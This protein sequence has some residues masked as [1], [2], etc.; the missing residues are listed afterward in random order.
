MANISEMIANARSIKGEAS[1]AKSYLMRYDVPKSI[2]LMI[3]ALHAKAEMPIVSAD[4]IDIEL[5]VR[6]YCCE[7]DKNQYVREVLTNVAF[8]KPQFLN[9]SPEKEREVI[10]RLV[11]MREKMAEIEMGEQAV[12]QKE[13]MEK[14]EALINQGEELV[15]SGQLPKGRVALKRAAE[16]FGREPGVLAR[17]GKILLDA[18]E[19]KEA[20]EM[21][22]QAMD[23]HPKDPDG[24]A[25][26]VEACLAVE[27]LPGAEDAYL[28]AIKQFGE[29]PQTC[30]NLAK[31]YLR[32]RNRDK[33]EECAR[34]AY[35]LDNTLA[36]AKTIMESAGYGD[37][38]VEERIERP[39][40]PAR[41]PGGGTGSSASGETFNI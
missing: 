32:M 14:R 29:H 4:R 19:S 36:E 3:S 1:R 5:M 30:L 33:A 28:K 11:V 13:L 27:D 22:L 40:S 23:L 15:R 16:Q 20:R 39:A 25:L 17:V 26:L 10:N 41:K 34:R 24:Y 31:L 12:K 37:L 6:D 35:E 21:F 7:F 38:G 2:D 18:K 9:Y 8:S